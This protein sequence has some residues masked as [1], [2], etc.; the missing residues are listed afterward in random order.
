MGKKYFIV[1]AFLCMLVTSIRAV[2]YRIEENIPY[3]SS[4]NEYAR[5]RCK[6][7]VYYSPD[8]KDKPVVV[9]FHGGG[10]TGGE[11]FIPDQLKNDSLVVVG[12]NYRL[13]PNA[14]I[15]QI[16]DDA[17][18]AVAWTFQNI[19]NFGGNPDKIFLSGHS[20]GGYL[21]SLIGLD[22]KWLGEYGIDADSLSGL[23]PYSG[24]V[25]TH[26][27][28]RDQM[29]LSPLQPLIDEYAPLAHAR[30]DCAPYIIISGDRN[31]ELF[32]RYEENA[33]MWRLMKLINHPYVYIYELDGY[34][35]GDMAV[36]AH[37]ILKKHIH[38]ILSER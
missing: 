33:Y 8:F 19:E 18:A 22:K 29:G 20:A 23:I 3:S 26:Y 28:V 15:E 11:K 32:G 37:H 35:H 31:E 14:G 34:N 30:N 7:D 4:D 38:K 9:W 27:A 13:L 17:A 10:L 5:E 1:A 24:Q 25:L 21:I 2:N 16:V 12:V 36:P 6:L